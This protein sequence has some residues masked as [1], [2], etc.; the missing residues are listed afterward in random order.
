[1]IDDRMTPAELA[2]AL[3]GLGLNRDES[4]VALGVSTPT[5]KNW[6]TGKHAPPPGVADDVA[7]LEDATQ[8]AV[9]ALAAE[10]DAADEPVV[11]VWRSNDAMHMARPE[12]G[13]WPARWW[14]QVAARAVRVSVTDARIEFGDDTGS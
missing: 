1:M 3:D 2:C 10:L 14:R 6:L 9:T 13:G 7:D 11:V 4:A 12:L 5:V 8:R